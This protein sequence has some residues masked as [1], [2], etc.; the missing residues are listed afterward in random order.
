MKKHNV[1]KRKLLQKKIN[2]FFSKNPKSN[3]IIVKTNIGGNKTIWKVEKNSSNSYSI[4]EVST[5]KKEFVMKEEPLGGQQ[6]AAALPTATPQNATQAK[7]TNSLQF[8]QMDLASKLSSLPM[9]LNYDTAIQTL[10]DIVESRSQ[11]LIQLRKILEQYTN[12][13]PID[14][15][16]KKLLGNLLGVLTAVSNSKSLMSGKTNPTLPQVKEADEKTSSGDEDLDQETGLEAEP[17]QKDEKTPINNSAEAMA[18]SNSLKGHTIRSANIELKPDG[19]LITLDLV[20]VESPSE[21]AWN[22][23][24][25]V[26]FNFKDRPYLLRK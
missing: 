23:S 26:V 5:V 3:S 6:P 11:D 8:G 20:S 14:A 19:G 13:S 9:M 16:Q 25:K 2:E 4:M 10:A 1:I 22:N 21:I 18:F 24:G 15:N 12:S 17:E 7:K